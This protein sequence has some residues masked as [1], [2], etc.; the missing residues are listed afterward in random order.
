MRP[1]FTRSLSGPVDPGRAPSWAEH[2]AGRARRSGALRN[3]AVWAACRL[4]AD[5]VSSLP[6]DVYQRRPDGTQNPMDT[7]DVLRKP[8]MRMMEWLYSTQ[9]DLDR[10][11]N[12]FGLISEVDD[13]ARPARIDLVPAD[14]VQ[15]VDR[16]GEP[17]VYRYRGRDFNKHEMWHERQYTV[18][19]LAIGLSPVA[20]AAMTLSSYSSAQEFALDWYGGYGAPT[21]VL[22]NTRHAN[23]GAEAA[24]VA[25][26]RFKAGVKTGEP[27]VTGSEWTYT[28][29]AGQQADDAWLAQMDA[30]SVEVARFFGVPADLIDAASKGSS[31]TYANITQRNLQF[32]IMH[33]GPVIA[34]REDAL[35]SK[36]LGPGTFVKLNSDAL[37]RMDPASSSAMLGQQV[38]DRLRAPSE[39][40]KLWDMEPFTDEQVAE[41]DQLFP[42]RLREAPSN[43]NA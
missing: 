18:P 24:Q 25:K 1:L 13:F 7:P 30:T 42:R 17:V 11:G 14:Q 16:P 23:I 5:L 21:A 10:Y 41:F 31:V 43:D 4:R 2:S 35:T 20:H 19:G 8:S 36:L 34:R 6:I 37:L 39:V 33:L 38:R 28:P 3:S 15:V 27:F 26:D 12:T 29:V 32:L 40:R 9:M 22:Q